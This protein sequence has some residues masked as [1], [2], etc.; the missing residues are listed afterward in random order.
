MTI[1]TF[2]SYAIPAIFM[3]AVGFYIPQTTWPSNVQFL[4]YTLSV[5]STFVAKYYFDL[6]CNKEK[7]AGEIKTKTQ[8]EKKI[9]KIER[10]NLSLR[11]ELMKC[12]LEH[13]DEVIR[14]ERDLNTQLKTNYKSDSNETLWTGI[15]N[16]I[17]IIECVSIESKLNGIKSNLK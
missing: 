2:L 8:L 15:N 12:K 6:F 3:A 14:I 17:K 11:D 5:M 7:T 16:V 10:E 9:A 1:Y 4:I 13:I